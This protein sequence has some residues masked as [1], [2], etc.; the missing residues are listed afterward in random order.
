MLRAL[1]IFGFG[2]TSLAVSPMDGDDGGVA[3]TAATT[4]KVAV[5]PRRPE[6]L[7]GLRGVGVADIIVKDMKRPTDTIIEAYLN[8]HMIS[9]RICGHC[10][11]TYLSTFSGQ[12]KNRAGT[13][14]YHFGQS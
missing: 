11:C 10:T 7:L 5:T 1:D 2:F 12:P 14:Y 13:Q 6:L 3:C 9:V 8:T 4:G